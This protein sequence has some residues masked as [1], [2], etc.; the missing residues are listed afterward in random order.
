[1]RTAYNIGMQYIK[2]YVGIMTFTDADGISKP[3][4][5]VWPNGAKYSISKVIDKRTAPPAHVG[6]SMTV[7]YTVQIQGR[8]RFIYYE[9]FSNKWFV[10]K[11]V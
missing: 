4:E 3:V 8:E 6:S 7:R 10:E 9:K 11:Q 5:L 1:M 2:V